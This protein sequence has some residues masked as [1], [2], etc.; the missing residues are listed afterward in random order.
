MGE[1]RGTV[2]C[3]YHI[4]NTMKNQ[5]KNTDNRI[6]QREIAVEVHKFSYTV[7]QKR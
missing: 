2:R 3:F 6:N 1:V 5:Q 4:G 7:S